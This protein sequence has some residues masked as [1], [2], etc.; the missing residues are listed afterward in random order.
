MLLKLDSNGKLVDII[1][2]Q[3]LI[4]PFHHEVEGQP[5]WGE[6][7]ADPE[8]YLKSDL[9][10][11]SGEHLPSCWVNSHYREYQTSTNHMK[12]GSPVPQYYGA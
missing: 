10:F 5:Q 3:A 1:D 7:L 11:L 12:K 9:R 2:I 8:N 4:N 6:D